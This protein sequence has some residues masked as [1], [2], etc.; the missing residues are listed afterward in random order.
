MHD[1]VE[2]RCITHTHT[3]D[4]DIDCWSNHTAKQL[5]IKIGSCDL[6]YLHQLELRCEG[7]IVCKQMI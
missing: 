7:E 6:E 4:K 1:T 5:Q 3:W 2:D